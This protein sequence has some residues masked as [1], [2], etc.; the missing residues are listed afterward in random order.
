MCLPDTAE[1]WWDV[2]GASQRRKD[3]HVF[4][5]KKGLECGHFHVYESKKIK[6]VDCH[7]CIKILKETIHNYDEVMNPPPPYGLC[8][9]G[10][11]LRL[12]KNTK[13]KELFLGCSNFPKCRYTTSNIPI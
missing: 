7:A 1:Y 10:G 9:C 6:Q 4:T 12:K 13:T 8:K 11:E 2:K 5:H 3:K